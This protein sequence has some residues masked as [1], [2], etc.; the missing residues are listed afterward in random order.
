MTIPNNPNDDRTDGV[1]MAWISIRERDGHYQLRE[2][3]LDRD[4][5]V[6]NGLNTAYVMGRLLKVA[7]EQ[8]RSSIL[9]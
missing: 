2:F 5:A 9:Q 3:G 4:V 1:I 8:Q 7:L 6:R